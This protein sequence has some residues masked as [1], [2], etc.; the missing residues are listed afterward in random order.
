MMKLVAL[1]LVT[2]SVMTLYETSTGTAADFKRLSTSQ[3]R[4]K[5]AGMEMTDHVHWVE[6]YRADGTV[7]TREMGVTRTGRWRVDANQLCVDL[8]KEGGQGCYE[9]WLSGNE[10]ELRIVESSALPIQGELQ[11][12]EARKQ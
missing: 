8:G 6:A 1:W 2:V 11:K 12:S 5:L 7:R 10:I 9:V 4:T 3:I